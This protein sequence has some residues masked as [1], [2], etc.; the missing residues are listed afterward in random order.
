M[1]SELVV[2]ALHEVDPGFTALCETLYGPGV[3]AEAAWTYLYG[4]AGVS[5]MSPGP[6][7]VSV[8]SPISKP[9][10]GV[11]VPKMPPNG[12]AAPAPRA[13]PPP[14]APTPV[15]ATPPAAMGVR[16]DVEHWEDLEAVDDGAYEVVWS[17]EFS[18][19]DD[20]RRQAF[21]YASVVEVD[22][23]P[24][25]DLQ[26]DWI[27]PAELEKAAY[28]FVQKSRVGGSQHARGD[29]GGPL[30]AGDMIESF[31]ITDE[32]VEKMGLPEDTPRGWWVGF[33]YHDDATWDDIKSGRKTGFSVHGRGKRVPVE[34]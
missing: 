33:Q 9:G 30:H 29:D 18:K 7:D 22:G 23:T 20:E 16:K 31:V 21:G 1:D 17:G 26:G 10:K 27:T 8:P 13:V 19:R 24:V 32:K 6:S 28:A 3:D 11:L 12:A 14:A 15:K 5:K 25:I 2:K 34:I 4:P